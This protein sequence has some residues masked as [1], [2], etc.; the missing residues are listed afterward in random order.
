M[1]ATGMIRRGL[2]IALVLA[3]CAMP[4]AAA[5][6]YAAR[7]IGQSQPLYLQRSAPSAYLPAGTRLTVEAVQDGWARVRFNGGAGFMPLSGLSGGERLIGFATETTR[8]YAS[9]TEFSNAIPVGMGFPMYV[10]GAIGPFYAVENA[11]GTL[12]YA[13]KIA[14]SPK[15][16]R[17]GN[18]FTGGY[19]PKWS[20]GDC[21]LMLPN[22]MRLY[23]QPRAN[24]AT[25][26]LSS[27]VPCR[28]LG[29]EGGYYRISTLDRRAV[30]YFQPADF[31]ACAAAQRGWSA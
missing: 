20:H 13:L 24:A 22:G 29:L 3:L 23:A 17:G 31:V 10:I 16:P 21:M 4:C 27:D 25:A 28:V 9:P 11:D 14:V 15:L 8:I 26:L 19:D 7:V 2:S 1:K 5:S 12:G 30:A 18:P 6:G